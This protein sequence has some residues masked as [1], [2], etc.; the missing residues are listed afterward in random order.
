MRHLSPARRAALLVALALA[1]AACSPGTGPGTPPDTTPP[2]GATYPGAA[3]DRADPAAEGFDPAKLDEIAAEAEANDSNC[4][5]VVRHGRIVADW[6]WNGTDAT[7]AQEVFSTTKS[8]TSTLVGLAQEDGDLAI[9]DPASTYIPQWAG[10][11]SAG[12]T[13]EDL[14]SN[15]SGRQ[16]SLGL[17]YRDLVVARDRTAFA[18][19]LGQDA[20]P[21]EVWAYNNAA[22]QTL[23]AVLEQA[24]GVDPAAYAEERL[25]GPIGMS[26]SEMTHDGA[27][28]TNT[29]FGLRSTCED[30]ARF[31]YLFLRG[32]EWDGTPVVPGDWVAAATGRSSQDINAAY[33][34]LWW[35][36]R[37]GPITDPLHPL[38]REDSETAPDRQLAAGA[39]A[40][41]YWA[42]GLGGQVVQVDP[43]SDTVVVRLGPGN[44]SA[45]YNQTNTARVVTE[46][47]VDG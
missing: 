26:H 9:T 1:T 25:L 44:T 15:D 24:T 45:T 36:N 28:N 47:I 19:G 21:G 13:V 17:D 3:W 29:F 37:R 30:L 40:D 16:W 10:T 46:A 14:I 39:P 2:G 8:F 35:L 4:M 11:P 42:R 23:D 43:G 20:E 18:V 31:G 22:I 5:V 12:V 7:T 33:G 32:G 41:M 6:Y 27:G 34:Y 38:T